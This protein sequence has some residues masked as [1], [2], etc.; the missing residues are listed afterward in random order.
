MAIPLLLCVFGSLLIISLSADIDGDTPISL[1]QSFTPS[2]LHKHLLNRFLV[3]NETISVAYFFLSAVSTVKGTSEITT[4]ILEGD[5][6]ITRDSEVS[7]VFHSP[8]ILKKT[9]L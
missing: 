6:H 8:E 3:F 4:A 9:D 2:E 7:H 5:T 1:S